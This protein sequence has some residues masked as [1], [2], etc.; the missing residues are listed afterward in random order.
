MKSAMEMNK[1][2]LVPFCYVTW[3]DQR[4]NWRPCKLGSVEGNSKRLIVEIT[5]TY[6]AQCIS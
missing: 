5:K 6:L 2:L 3:F 1:L 4:Q